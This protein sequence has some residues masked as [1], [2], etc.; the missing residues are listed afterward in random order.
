MNDGHALA[1]ACDI[2]RKHGDL[3]IEFLDQQIAISLQKG[4]EDKVSAW[5]RVREMLVQLHTIAFFASVHTDAMGF[6]VAAES[7]ELQGRF[8]SN[9]GH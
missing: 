3:S 4:D 8:N 5:G 6:S 1:V 9:H 7:N 2:E